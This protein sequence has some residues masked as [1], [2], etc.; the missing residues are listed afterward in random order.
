MTTTRL[1]RLPWLLG[2]T[3]LAGCASALNRAGASHPSDQRSTP[4]L[5]TFRATPEQ[6]SDRI[7][8]FQ[9]AC[10]LKVEQP[11]DGAQLLL[12]RAIQRDSVERTAGSTVRYAHA[13]GDYEPLTRGALGLGRRDWLRLDCETLRSVAVVPRGA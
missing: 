11:G 5:L 6:P 10:P 12:R 13:L 7:P 1:T 2:I 4:L 9:A 8:G 3:F